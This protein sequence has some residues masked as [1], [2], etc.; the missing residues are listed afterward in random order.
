MNRAWLVVGSVAIGSGLVGCSLLVG[1]FKECDTPADCA[2]GQLCSPEGYCVDPTYPLGCNG[3]PDAGVLAV[4]GAS[5]AG[6]AIH[7]GAALP[8]TDSLG[9]PSEINIAE[10]NG[11]V[12]AIEEIN[13]RSGV[14]GR[15]FALHV[16]DFNFTGVDNASV[17]V[18]EQ[19]TWLADTVGVPAVIVANSFAVLAVAPITQGR[20]VVLMSANAT[21]PEISALNVADAGL[22]LVWRTAPSDAI[23]GEVINQLLT[24]AAVG[25][26][27]P[28]GGTEPFDAGIADAQRIGIAYVNDPYG[29]GLNAILQEGLLGAKTFDSLQYTRG[30]DITSTVA[31][32]DGFDPDLTVLIGFPDDVTRFL[33][34][35][36]ATANLSRDAGHRWLFTDAAKAPDLLSGTPL[37][38]DEGAYGTA[39]AKGAGAAYSIFAN[40]F[41]ARFGVSADNYAFVENDYD[42][43]Y[44]LALASAYAVGS[45]GDGGVTGLA[46]ADGL[47]HLSSGASYSLTPSAF[48]SARGALQGG[49]S[50]D[51]EGASG[52]LDFNPATGEA[53]APIQLWQIDGGTIVERAVITP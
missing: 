47:T 19:V 43:V 46:L 45:S 31:G 50:I 5:D 51:V 41:A 32:L 18:A 35:A 20:G 52:H 3:N 17:R 12:L 38:Q 25:A 36:P 40:S 15:P 34:A 49:G 42:A 37:E 27:L 6:N 7:L 11:Q 4:Y 10:L 13:Q 21:S 16:C 14:G 30:G 39:P 53:P 29:Q 28:D 22:P 1:N 33:S 9:L 26:S 48:T 2:G 23:Q 8:I 24:G 44:V